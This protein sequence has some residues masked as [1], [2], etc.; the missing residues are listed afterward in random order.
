MLPPPLILLHTQTSLISSP[1][2][3]TN[4]LRMCNKCATVHARMAGVQDFLK[5]HFR[6]RN[7]EVWVLYFGFYLHVRGISCA[8]FSSILIGRG[9]F[10][11][12]EN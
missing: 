6:G 8:V 12:T 10:E 5:C 4:S 1:R 3:S 11:M 2:V 9:W 7:K